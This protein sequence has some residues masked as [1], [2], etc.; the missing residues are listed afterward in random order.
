M[1]GVIRRNTGGRRG[2]C[3]LKSPQEGLPRE[4]GTGLC[5]KADENLM[6]RTVKRKGGEHIRYIQ[7]Q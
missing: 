7:R 6:N 1:N 2:G 5:L 3:R 4:V